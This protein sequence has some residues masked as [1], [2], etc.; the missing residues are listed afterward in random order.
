MQTARD[1]G[2]Q[3]NIAARLTALF[4][5]HHGKAA[6]IS[7]LV[8]LTGGT[9]QESWYFA[10][11]TDKGR[12]RRYILR[13]APA[14]HQRLEFLIADEARLL[15]CLHARGLPAAEVPIILTPEDGLG[16][17]F[18]MVFY[19]GETLAGKILHDDLYK[20]TRP[21]LARQC[22]QILA[23]IHQTPADGLPALPVMGVREQIANYRAILEESKAHRP[24]FA[25]AFRW[26][27]GHCPAAAPAKL[28]HGD[29]RNGNLIIGAE[30]VR[31]VLDWELAHCGDPME[32][33][34]WLCVGSWR[35]GVM[36]NPVGGFGSYRDLFA[37]Y[38]EAGGVVDKARRDFWEIM[39][40]AKWGVMC[41]MMAAR[42]QASVEQI[43]VGRRASETELDLLALLAP[44]E[45]KGAIK[46]HLAARAPPR[47]D[48]NLPLL[49]AVG[50]FLRHDARAVLTG[51]VRFHSVV[52]ANAL[53]IVRRDVQQG[54]AA[55]AREQMRAA[56]LLG[57]KEKPLEV[58]NPLLCAKIDGG[59]ITL[60]TKGFARHLWL[61]VLD[62]LAIE[63]PHY[64][65]YRNRV[66]GEKA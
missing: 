38:E 61:T 66:T 54:E 58:L 63:Q 29:F 20:D 65:S 39:G 46:E 17:G 40:T 60:A 10:V 56:E 28:V 15:Q 45:E 23:A 22:G 32:D 64:A 48:A 36:E 6:N 2:K 12:A 25:Y 26:L 7:G 50:D 33:L 18:I 41:M 49:A 44:E 55:R 43:A 16:E 47:P 19:D 57:Q 51:R 59:E 37:G 24:V 13:L 27:A 11:K 62:R 8:Q 9:S 42:E 1:S 52:A 4:T 14:A 30:G 31:R 34:G 53:D 21:L 35:F 5:R 3:E